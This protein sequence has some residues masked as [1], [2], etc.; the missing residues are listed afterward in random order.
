MKDIDNEVANCEQ[1]KPNR[2]LLVEH[3]GQK[4]ETG[5]K[6]VNTMPDGNIGEQDAAATGMS[7]SDRLKKK[8]RVQK[9]GIILKKERIEG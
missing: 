4:Q 3:N 5:E 9:S 6:T 1:E 7:G 8:K 2:G